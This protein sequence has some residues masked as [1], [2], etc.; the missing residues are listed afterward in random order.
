MVTATTAT[1]TDTRSFTAWFADF[2]RNELAPYPG[3]GLIV[4]RMVIAATITMIL[5]M[6]FR[7]PGGATG[8]LYA[9]L[10]S[11][12]N[13][14]STAKS[15]VYLLIAIAL[16]TIFVPLGA[17]MFASIPLT[18]FLW[19]AFSLFLIF[20]LIRTLT[21]YSIAS[22][23]GLIGTTAIATWYLP[24][25]AEINLERTLWI[26]LA[27]AIGAAV[28]LAVEAVFH[29]FRKEDELVIGLK[30]RLEALRQLLD[31]YATH[32]AVSTENERKLT[33]Y[34]MVGVGGLRRQL[35]RSNYEP[36]YRAKMQ[37]VVSLVGRS[38]DFAAALIHAHPQISESD[39]Q[40]SALLARQLT[41]IQQSLASGATPPELETTTLSA[42]TSLL[43]ELEEM[44]ALIP[45]VIAGTA[46]IESFR[47]LT[48]EPT[49]ESGVFVRD[50]FTNPE[51]LYFA[52]SG[53]LAGM[54]CYVLYVSLAWPG[55]STSVTT[56]VLTALS[57]V[58][59]SRQKQVLRIAGAVLG[60]FVF[61]L[62]AQIFVLPYID[63]IVGFTLLF[64]GVSFV[65]GWIGTAS[66]RLSYCGLQVALAF[67]LIH[68]NDFTI[69]LSLSI[70]R[71]RALGVL[72][73]IVM[74]WLVFDRLQPTTATAQMVGVFCKN[75]R[76]LAD[77]TLLNARRAD[78]ST[79]TN[80]RRLRDMIYGNFA[81]V[82]SQADAVP[83]EL[84]ALRNQHMA[85]R[86]RI[87]RWQA[88]LR[89][90]YLLELALLQYRAFGTAEKP[91]AEMLAAL[92]DFDQ[93]CK[94]T[95]KDMAHYLE[96]QQKTGEPHEAGIERPRQL[97]ISA[98]AA[99]SS[100]L[101]IANQLSGILVRLREEMLAAPL[102]T[103]E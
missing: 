48:H 4:A 53:S 90:F 55:L 85:A 62:G 75:L 69:Q 64:I 86:D 97:A 15:A 93:S 6:T 77:L 7:I 50:A 20:F 11:R 31:C 81:T 18:H 52:L 71:D 33:Q 42:T 1:R 5:I 80:A 27:P 92:E 46:S 79:I 103:V 36:L 17:R 68:V 83:F 101:S 35:V 100:S 40:L 44:I 28:T 91:S 14:V 43:R 22:A 82:N 34:A 51:H 29:A 8:P 78:V 32:A 70:A 25:P 30:T 73:G 49:N 98:E 45:R 96:I 57:T 9:F 67:Y 87:R 38:I 74:M 84:G 41:E 23:I 66:S 37:A 59:A 19:E 72:L 61:G 63:S 89:T 99:N 56:C 2:L 58:G 88:M 39:K 3:R 16:A 54:L 47:V 60:G 13:L 12:E 24:G 10:I 102:F 94:R 95:L 76:L 21:N 65:A 26:V